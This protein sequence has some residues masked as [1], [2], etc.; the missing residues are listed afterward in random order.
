MSIDVTNL[1]GRR[2]TNRWERTSV[3][4]VLERLTWSQPDAEAIIGWDGAYGDPRYERLTYR[5]ADELANQVAGGLMARGLSRGD[6]VMLYCENSVEAYVAKIGIAK[7]GMVA[8]PI[9]PSLAPDVVQHLIEKTEPKFTIVDA[10]L[11]PRAEVPFTAAGLPLDVTITIGGD[12]VSGSIS[13]SEFAGGN[14][15]TEPDVE[16]H[17][18]DIWQILFTSGTT[19]LPKGVMISHTSSMFAAYGFALT[20]TR[21]VHIES[22]LKLATFLPII[23]HVADQIFTFPSFLAGGSLVIGRRPAPEPIAA[24]IDRER[25]TALWAGSPAMVD[26]LAAV[27]TADPGRYDLSSLRVAVYGWAALSPATLETL[28]REC[29]AELV[30]VEIFGQTESISCHRFWPD[31]WSDLYLRTAPEHN[32][33]GI[34]SPLLASRLVDAAGE[35]IGEAGVPGEAV[36]R[37]PSITAG[38]YLDETATQ[39]AF[40]GGWFHSGDSCVYGEDGHRIMV[41]RFKD[42]VKSGGENVSTIRVESVLVQ[43]PAVARAAVIGVPHE[44][45]GEAVT[46]VVV[47]TKPEA[48]SEDDIL[49]FC[50]DRLAGFETPKSVIF[51]DELPETVGGKVLKYKLRK[52]Y[53]E[54]FTTS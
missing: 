32:Y 24:A 48:A 4:D 3:G 46:A 31:K 17:G 16:I 52:Q 41:D 25:V 51:V 23:Y 39:E 8:T 20:L 30:V 6:R 43:H 42:I 13:F 27:V 50:R 10:E 45:W 34:P 29:G 2:A 47:P 40:R 37:S 28:K 44:R 12:A 38:Y 11:W 19:A 15:A 33:V 7:A 18:D 5:Q 1:T 35:V 53:R 49:A 9:N 26:A 54:L 21:G 14:Q 22:D 36:Y